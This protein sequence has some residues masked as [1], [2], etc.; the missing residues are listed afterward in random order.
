[1]IGRRAALCGLAC[2][3]VVALAGSL[4]LGALLS[5]SWSLQRC[6]KQKR[7]L[8]GCLAPSWAVAAR[9]VTC[10]QTCTAVGDCLQRVQRAERAALW[11]GR[12]FRSSG[13]F[14]R[15]AKVYRHSASGDAADGPTRA[16]IEALLGYAP[17]RGR[18]RCVDACGGSRPRDRDG[19]ERAALL[20]PGAMAAY[21]RRERTT[22]RAAL[23]R[24]RARARRRYGFARAPRLDAALG[25]SDAACDVALHRRL[26]DVLTAIP[27][28]TVADA[29]VLAA[30]DKVVRTCALPPRVHVFTEAFALGTAAGAARAPP[31]DA[32]EH[33]A[34]PD[35]RGRY[36]LTFRYLERWGR[37]RGINTTVHAG[38]DVTLAVHGMVTAD[39]LVV[40]P[41]LF[42]ATAAFPARGRVFD[43]CGD[44]ADD[45]LFADPVRASYSPHAVSACFDAA[46][47]HPPHVAAMRDAFLRRREGA[48]DVARFLE[49]GR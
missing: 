28:R 21:A 15:G 36:A 12:A 17:E 46:H 8:W 20:A 41:S 40:A 3:V 32:V 16:D 38:G 31:P 2:V 37:R 43:A 14:G 19:P 10:R 30:L 22:P 26:G 33:D 34:A 23:A 4:A 35:G 47:A 13:V 25:Y 5:T 24:A 45:A 27:N 6:R 42:S 1:M 11:H 18:N 49:R 29:G 48:M 9:C 44:A 39:V 7:S